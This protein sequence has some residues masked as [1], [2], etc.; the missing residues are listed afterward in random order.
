M[1]K[2]LA[3]ILSVCLLASSLTACSGNDNTATTAAASAAAEESKAGAEAGEKKEETAPAEKVTFKMGST[4]PAGSFHETICQTFADN[5]K[6]VSGGAMTVEVNMGGVLGNTL[7]HYSQLGQGDLDFFMA[8]L[9]T[10]SGLKEGKDMAVVLVP[11]LFNDEKHYEKF[12]ESDLLKDMIG[13]IEQANG[14]KFMGSL[15]RQ[16]PRG[17]S[18]SNTPVHSVE[19]V[20]NLKIRTPEATAMTTI[21][22]AWGANPTVISGGELYSALQSGLADGQDNDVINTSTSAMYEVQKYYME[23]NYIYQN[24]FLWA[25]AKNMEALT[26]EQRSQIE[27]ALSKTYTEMS[28]QLDSMY[29]KEKQTMIDNG[30]EFVDVDVDSFRKATDAVVGQ[31]D[32]KLYTKGLYEEIKALAD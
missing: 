2:N 27:E 8:A 12:L 28:A 20:K 4:S 26:D 3:I 14:L 13:K 19:D 18:T 30:V 9:D 23:I 17:L 10:S 21:W 15:S 32:D 31:F 24:L 22:A 16:M 7:S 1:K 25:S 5:V 11:F 29:E 6:E